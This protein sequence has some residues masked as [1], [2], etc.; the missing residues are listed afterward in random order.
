MDER[1]QSAMEYLMTYGW[2]ILII[3]VV[4]GAIYSLGLFS[5]A[6][7]GPRAQPGACQVLRPNG[8][9]TTQYV[10]LGGPCTNQLP[11]YVATI[12][13]TTFSS[14][15][16]SSSQNVGS[17]NFSVAFW[18]NPK[19]QS[20]GVDRHIVGNTQGENLNQQ[21]WVVSFDNR[22]S[23]LGPISVRLNDGTGA[24]DQVNYM[25]YLASINTSSWHFAVA[26]VSLTSK[27]V[28]F[29]VDG[30]QDGSPVTFTYSGT[31]QCQQAADLLRHMRGR[32]MRHKQR[33]AICQLPDL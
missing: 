8:P 26:V 4:L 14:F 1:S 16:A 33:S 2:A 29:Y 9:G 17:T 23:G 28:T 3:A 6:T 19:S 18:I 32:A 11:Q 25:P 13:G 10:S 24:S 12:S 20:N 15:N 31:V 21:K 22:N 7:L 5:P 30:K 27:S